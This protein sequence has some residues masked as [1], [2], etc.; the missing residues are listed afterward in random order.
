MVERN[1]GKQFFRI[2]VIGV[3]LFYAMSVLVALSGADWD[4]AATQLIVYPFALIIVGVPAYL[5]GMLF[6]IKNGRGGPPNST[7]VPAGNSG[8]GD[9]A[10]T[11]HQPDADTIIRFA[12]LNGVSVRD[13]R[14]MNLLNITR[15]GV[16]YIF[17]FGNGNYYTFDTL[18]AAER[19]ACSELDVPVPSPEINEHT[20]R[21]QIGVSKL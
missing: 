6:P 4:R 19:F 18:S 15:D 1:R 14:I 20:F 8:L 11:H 7:T 16:K 2:V 5:L 10:A 9:N 3:S 17:H 12:D 13:A 21:D